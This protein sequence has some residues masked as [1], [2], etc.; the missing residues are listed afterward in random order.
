L[1]PT[2]FAECLAT[3]S[4]TLSIPEITAVFPLFHPI[5]MTVK[6]AIL[7]KLAAGLVAFGLKR[8]EFL[9][10]GPLPGQS[11][12]RHTDN[13]YHTYHSCHHSFHCLLLSKVYIFFV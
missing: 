10:A 1:I 2:G 13:T 6:F 7:V 4:P 5:L 12:H 8:P 3:F 9:A 11:R